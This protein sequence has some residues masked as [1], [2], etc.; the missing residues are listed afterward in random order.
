MKRACFKIL[1]YFRPYIP[2][3]VLAFIF[4]SVVVGV[5]VYFPKIIE[6]LVDE[7]I[8]TKNL[9]L[10][11]HLIWIGIGLLLIKGV[12]G[13]LQL[14]LISYAG[15][16][17][18]TDL[19]RDLFAHLMRLSPSFYTRYPTGGLISRAIQ[20]ITVIREMFIENFIRIIPLFFVF[21]GLLV[22]MFLLNLKMALLISL[23]LPLIGYLM[24]RFGE[25][26]RLVS[27]QLQERVDRLSSLIQETITCIRTVISFTREDYEKE[28]FNKV[29]EEGCR[30]AVSRSKLRGIQEVVIESVTVLGIFGI[31]W[32]AS[33]QLVEG[34]ITPGKLSAF[35]FCVILIADPLTSISRSY[36]SWEKA[37]ASIE[38]II[39]IMEVKEEVREVRGAKAMPR[40]EGRVQFDGVYFSYGE[41]EIL[42]GIDL[43]VMEGERV[44][45]VGRSGVGKT[46]LLNLIPRFFDPTKG[47]VRIDGRDIREVTLRSL[48]AQVGVV[49]QEP[50]LFSGT[51]LSNILYGRLD[52]S[53]D[54]VFHAAEAANIRHLISGSKHGNDIQV[55]ERGIRLSS[56]ECQ[57]VAIARA[58][59]KDPRI[60][61][62]DEPTSH[63]DSESE[64][65]V[66]EALYRLMEG[67]TTFIIAHRLSTIMGA[68][69]LVV[70]DDGRIVEEGTHTEL[71]EKGGLYATLFRAQL[72]V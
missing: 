9:T 19:R 36:F 64:A 27:R 29:N 3:M 42:K 62:L 11:A 33:N 57:R 13:Y 4:T 28:R 15:Q 44:A 53:E 16:R 40:I 22:R 21:V 14:Y 49:P 10:L 50:V 2:H 32:L 54:D 58:I 41:R 8:E 17:V 66:N 48:R 63:L 68:D 46:T 30:V 61:I 70:L 65:L 38:R 69:R 6:N 45:V 34:D 59:L 20:D 37:V 24:A 35:F 26:A 72:F 71:L 47:I 23:F 31:I 60:V 1:P 7:A 55:G 52:A 67:R 18:V 51:I 25:R 39:E 43:E 12:A 5:V 56:G